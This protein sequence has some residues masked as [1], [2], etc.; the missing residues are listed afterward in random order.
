MI[1]LAD[2]TFAVKNDPDQLD[3]NPE[4]MNRLQEIHPSTISDYS[5][6][7]GPIAWVLIFPTTNVLMHRFLS[8]EIS[9]KELFFL[10]PLDVQYDAIYLCSALVL[11]EYRRKCITK[12]LTLSAIK[13]IQQ[14]HAI[15]A[16][17]VWPFSNEGEK[18]AETIAH[19]ALLPLYKRNK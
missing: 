19:L 3:V 10:T 5:D 12:Q 16:L 6:E 11:E 7:N 17:F 4:V 2:E 14:Q 9:E 1:Q 15:K 13:N 18:G 8:K